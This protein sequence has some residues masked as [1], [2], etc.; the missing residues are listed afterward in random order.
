MDCGNK[1]GV[2]KQKWVLSFHACDNYSQS[3]RQS[4]SAIKAKFTG[5][6]APHHEYD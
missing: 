2:A 1:M 6:S 5:Y 3:I 4:L